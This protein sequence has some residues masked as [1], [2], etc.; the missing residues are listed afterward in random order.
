MYVVLVLLV[1]ISFRRDFFIK[2]GQVCLEIDYFALNIINVIEVVNQN[3]SGLIGTNALFWLL[4]L[5]KSYCVRF[6]PRGFIPVF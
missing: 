2:K 5:L 3:A 4:F 1:V 6:N